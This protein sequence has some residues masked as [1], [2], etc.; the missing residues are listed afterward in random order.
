MAGDSVVYDES[1]DPDP[2]VGRLENE[3]RVVGPPGCGKTT[4]LGQEAEKTVD[5][6]EAVLLASFTRAAAAEIVAHRVPIPTSQVGTLHSF[7]FR[8]LDKPP[9]ALDKKV[10]TDW[11]GQHP[12]YAITP[13]NGDFTEPVHARSQEDPSRLRGDRL[14]S[15]YELYRATMTTDRMPPTVRHFAVRWTHWKREHGLCDFTD[16]IEESLQYVPVGPSN[17][18]VIL[19]DEAQDL[20]PLELR[21]V[22][23]WGHQARR[24]IL[25]GDPDQ[26]IYTWRGAREGTMSQPPSAG[27]RL[28]LAQSYRV[29]R[30]IHAQAVGWINK[31]PTRKR[32]EYWPRPEQGELVRSRATWKDPRAAIDECERHL[33][34][35]HKVMFLSSCAYLLAPLLSRLRQRGIP[36][37]NPYRRSNGDWNPL[38]RRRPP[39]MADRLR[40][41]LRLSHKGSWSP[42]DIMTW[43][44][45][46]SS[47][48]ALR[49]GATQMLGRLIDSEIHTVSR[50]TMLDLLTNDAMEA[51]HRGDLQWFRRHIKPGNGRA[52]EYPLA[53]GERQGPRALF[54]TPR[55]TVGTVHSVKGAEVDVVFLLPDL[56]GPG[57]KG[58]CGS[59]TA[60]ASVSRLFYV[61]MTRARE[62]LVL[63]S[64]G[65]RNAVRF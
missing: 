11:N 3:F 40:A 22:R 54:E 8:I 57:M 21:L 41:Y 59:S 35:N 30:E 27:R 58:W 49:P 46:C 47:Q 55:L 42:D 13:V 63:L 38:G 17:P 64:P 39:S 32:V 15:Q 18:A 10:L 26:T 56:S 48:D 25:V 20:S 60:R 31:D 50:E 28:V 12:Q 9:I 1:P 37:H 62:T 61:G 6:G 53:V 44:W 4:W 29:P 24:L 36:Y 16:L 5:R 33:D 52:A 14:L 43:T 51:A 19:I 23:K 34:K 65:G 2:Q 45:A 7:C